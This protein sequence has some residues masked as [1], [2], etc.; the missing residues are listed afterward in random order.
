MAIN[1]DQIRL[2]AN[3]TV[4]VAPTGTA[5]PADFS[6][7]FSGTWVDLGSLDE[8]GFSFTDSKTVTDILIWQMLYPGRKIIASRSFSMDFV[9]REWS[10][11][12][13]ALAFGGGTWATTGSGATTVHK[14]SPPDPHT[15]DTRMMAFDW[16][17][18]AITWRLVLYQG[19]VSGNVASKV[20]RTAAV[21]LPITFDVIGRDGSNPYDLS[22]NDLAFS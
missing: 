15:I 16:V 7:S 18:N 2:G 9:L 14:Y 21:D 1:T 5:L 20:M 3:G 11:A 19:L 13:V 17:D 6:A 12:T 4:R 22:C 8:N 10:Q